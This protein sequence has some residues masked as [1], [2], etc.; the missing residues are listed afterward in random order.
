MSLTVVVKNSCESPFLR[1]GRCTRFSVR[2]FRLSAFLAETRRGPS[3][4]ESGL[5]TLLKALC[6]RVLSYDRRIPYFG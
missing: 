6:Q 4:P 1:H 3:S 5:M 2:K